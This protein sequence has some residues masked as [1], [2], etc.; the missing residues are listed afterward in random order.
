MIRTLAA[1]KVLGQ[2][3]VPGSIAQPAAEIHCLIGLSDQSGLGVDGEPG[4]GWSC[5]YLGLCKQK[6][7]HILLVGLGQV[8]SFL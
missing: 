4:E 3:V 1:Q 8:I 2:R 6:P 7:D 5:P